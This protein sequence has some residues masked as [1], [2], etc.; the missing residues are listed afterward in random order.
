MLTES[1]YWASNNGHEYIA[2]SD[3]QQAIDY[4]THRLDK[5]REKLYENIHRGTVLIDT[6]GKVTGQ[7]NGLSVLQLG[8][9]SFG[10]PS[11]IT[12]T[13][14]WSGLLHCYL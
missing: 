5:L 6:E 12:A 8:E 11:R 14:R 3:V 13:T 9:F 4:K 7:V 1:D 2:N 10:Q